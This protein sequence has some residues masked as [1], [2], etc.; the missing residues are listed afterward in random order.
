MNSDSSSAAPQPSFEVQPLGF[1][2]E[3]YTHY[4][5][6]EKSVMEKA[7]SLLLAEIAT[8]VKEAPPFYEG[9]R[10]RDEHYN[11]ANDTGDAVLRT[12]ATRL[13]QIGLHYITSAPTALNSIATFEQRAKVSEHLANAIERWRLQAR[14]GTY[15]SIKS[16]MLENSAH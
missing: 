2:L 1:G 16:A 6:I 14:T 13:A 3:I 15:L 9:V 8:A 4:L 7:R 5:F 11:F 12:V 10:F